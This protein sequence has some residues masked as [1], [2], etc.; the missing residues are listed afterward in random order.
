[1]SL[2]FNNGN[3]KKALWLIDKEEVIDAKAHL[4]PGP[5]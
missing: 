4:V 5:A 1:M 2:L 3:S